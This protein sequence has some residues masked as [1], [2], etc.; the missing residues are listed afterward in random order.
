M[1]YTSNRY[2]RL[3]GSLF[4]LASYPLQQAKGPWTKGTRPQPEFASNLIYS[5]Y[6]LK[7]SAGVSEGEAEAQHTLRHNFLHFGRS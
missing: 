2:L 3:S 5:K 7:I 6:M 1:D 4:P